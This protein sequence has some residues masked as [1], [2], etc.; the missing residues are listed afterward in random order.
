MASIIK[1]LFTAFGLAALT[2]VAAAGDMQAGRQI[3]S[4][5]CRTCHGLDG[6]AQIPVAPHLAGESEIYL[7]T[8]LKAFRSG[9][10]TNEM[11]DV[12]AKDLTDDDIAN[13]AAWYSS[14]NITVE[15]PE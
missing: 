3:A 8:Q 5:Q 13:V 12:V 7:Q 11:M 9:K 15:M 10:R 2:G 4:A 14:I 6:I 1:L